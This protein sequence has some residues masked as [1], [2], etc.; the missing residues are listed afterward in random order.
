[1]AAGL[2]IA[3]SA[4]QAAR[5]QGI[6]YRNDQNAPTGGANWS[7]IASDG[8]LSFAYIAATQADGL[9]A[10][11]NLSTDISGAQA[12]GLGVGTYALTSFSN[13][14]TTAQTQT[15]GQNYANAFYNA[16]V[17]ADSTI[18]AAGNLRPAVFVVSG[19]GTNSGVGALAFIQQFETDSGGVVPMLITN[20]NSQDM[21][22]ASPNQY[23]YFLTQGSVTA[24]QLD[25]GG[26]EYKDTKSFDTSA[27]QIA[28]GSPATETFPSNWT[29]WWYANTNSKNDPTNPVIANGDLKAGS[30][31]YQ[32]ELGGALSSVTLVPAP[33]SLAL[34]GVGVVLLLVDRRRCRSVK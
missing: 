3:P 25:Q 4:A 32:V 18:F 9:T 11:S 12:A 24:S 15:K 20:S 2:L 28:T 14:D 31:F 13:S 6:N 5:V 8:G 27:S 16:S 26:M 34:L 30:N 33:A 29:A 1:M 22:K 7:N 17:A 19:G 10:Q 23:A 21:S